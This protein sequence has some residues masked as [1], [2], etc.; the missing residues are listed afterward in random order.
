MLRFKNFL[1][2]IFAP[3]FVNYF[4]YHRAPM[5]NDITTTKAISNQKDTLQIHEIKTITSIG[6]WHFVHVSGSILYIF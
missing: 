2:I 4:W 5:K 1:S 6:P 3:N